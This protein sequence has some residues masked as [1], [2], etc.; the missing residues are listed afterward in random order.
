MFSPGE[1]VM[2]HMRSFRVDKII[3]PDG[4]CVP[5]VAADQVETGQP[6]PTP[7]LNTIGVHFGPKIRQKHGSS[8][9][10]FCYIA[11]PYLKIMQM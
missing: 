5:S 4:V 10:L 7:T 2:L 1:I 3:H 8:T 9:T 6:S 11:F